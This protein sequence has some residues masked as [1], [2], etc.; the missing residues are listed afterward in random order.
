MHGRI[1][2]GAHANPHF[3]ILNEMIPVSER[4]SAQT[5]EPLS[6]PMILLKALRKMKRALE[7]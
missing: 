5:Q 6:G 4:H 1:R 3:K 2:N 7:P